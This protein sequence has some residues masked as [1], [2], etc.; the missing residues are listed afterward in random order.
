[1]KQ[2]IEGRVDGGFYRVTAPDGS[3]TS[4]PLDDK[5]LKAAIARNGWQELATNG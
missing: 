1:M 2:R 5:K 3:V 4:Y